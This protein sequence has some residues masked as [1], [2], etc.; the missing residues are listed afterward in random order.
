MYHAEKLFFFKPYY[1]K[2]TALECK[3]KNIRFVI[4]VVDYLQCGALSSKKAFL[5]VVLIPIQVWD[6][7]NCRKI[8]F[9]VF[10][11]SMKELKKK[12]VPYKIRISKEIK[13]FVKYI[14]GDVDRYLVTKAVEQQVPTVSNIIKKEENNEQN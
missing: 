14:I 3:T 9:N 8:I 2:I 5:E 6:D 11:R 4:D 1:V 10:K 12:A 7:K 13:D